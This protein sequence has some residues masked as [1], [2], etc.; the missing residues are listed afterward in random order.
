[1]G[2]LGRTR[3]IP[4]ERVGLR[5]ASETDTKVTGSSPSLQDLRRECGKHR[6]GWYRSLRY[7]RNIHL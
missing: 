1:M 4:W 6:R 3:F 7:C 2:R 5:P